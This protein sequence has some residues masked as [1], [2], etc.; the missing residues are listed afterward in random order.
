M[1]P[2]FHKPLHLLIKR[3]DYS[4]GLSIN[5]VDAVLVVGELD[6]R[7]LNLFPLVFLL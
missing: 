5:E 2:V 6:E 3:W 1:R 4:V 7:P